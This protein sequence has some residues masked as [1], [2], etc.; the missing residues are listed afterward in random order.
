VRCAATTSRTITLSPRAAD[1]WRGLRDDYRATSQAIADMAPGLSGFLVKAPT[2]AARLAGLFAL[3]EGAAVASDGSME[4]A[5]I[6]IRHATATA[7]IAHQQVFAIGQPVQIA[8]RLA[9]RILTKGSIRIARRD[10]AKVDAFA[11]ATEPER[12]AAIDH[13]AGAGWLTEV[14][15]KRIR[16]GPRFREATAWRVNEL[17]HER[18]A[19]IAERERTAARNAIDRLAKLCGTPT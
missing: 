13:L 19:D 10:F 7:R 6:F 16:L 3:L 11:K 4:R 17:V 1:R 2:M 5:E 14:D 9:A 18:F 12:G 8:R 15:G